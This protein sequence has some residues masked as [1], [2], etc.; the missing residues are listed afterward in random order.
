[1]SVNS[2]S[3]PLVKLVPFTMPASVLPSATFN[4]Q[5]KSVMGATTRLDE[6]RR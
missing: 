6:S 2:D 1:M 3:I 4:S 5:S